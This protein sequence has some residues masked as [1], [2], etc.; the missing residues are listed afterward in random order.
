MKFAVF[1]VYIISTVAPVFQAGSQLFF[2]PSVPLARR[3][4]TFRDYIN[5]RDYKDYRDYRDYRDYTRY[6][7][8]TKNR[9]AL[10]VTQSA[11]PA[12]DPWGPLFMF[13]R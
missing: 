7:V 6:R 5:Y 9:A 11:P 12:I 4:R 13:T 1:S 2:S 3:F 10:W 8:Y